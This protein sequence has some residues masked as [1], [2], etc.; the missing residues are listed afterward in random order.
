MLGLG[1]WFNNLH[2]QTFIS[3]AVAISTIHTFCERCAEE[4]YE[5]HI[6]LPTGPAHEKTMEEYHRLIGL[7]GA[8]GSTDVMRVK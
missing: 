2:H 6:H 8:I 1:N 7:T 5:E 3:D 4:L